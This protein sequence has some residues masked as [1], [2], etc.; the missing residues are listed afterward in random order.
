[1][2]RDEETGLVTVHFF[3][4][5]MRFLV[6]L[7]I[8]LAPVVAHADKSYN[9]GKG[10]TW[11]C[12]KDAEI[13]INANKGTYTF[14]GACTHITVNGNSNKITVEKTANL[15]VNGNKN[16]IDVASADAISTNG[17]DNAVTYK[18]SP[19]VSGLGSRNKVSGTDKK[20]K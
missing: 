2:D 13:T 14:K 6:G 15:D 5:F 9:D 4:G 8:A 10:D 20:A 12:S 11:D 17:N 3:G 19:K 7:M 18:G 16:T 1:V